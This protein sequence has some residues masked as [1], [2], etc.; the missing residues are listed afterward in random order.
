M[1]T[2]TLKIPHNM[3]EDRL[4]CEGKLPVSL[5]VTDAVDAYWF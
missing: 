3:N 5:P 2:R 4:D 1:G